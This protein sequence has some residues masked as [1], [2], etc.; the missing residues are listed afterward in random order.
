MTR[1]LNPDTTLGDIAAAIP[2]SMA[3]F[4]R[5]GLDYCCGGKRTLAE[6]A[7]SAGLD[8]AE[9]LRRIEEA[10]ACEQETDERDWRNATM[11]ELADHIE[12]T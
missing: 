4:E 8:P 7:R 12:A 11:T 2:A 5:L 10:A 6:G 9:A 1:D 3:V